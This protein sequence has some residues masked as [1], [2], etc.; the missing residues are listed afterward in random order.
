[1]ALN[2]VQ[3]DL[4]V[5][6]VST[7]NSLREVNLAMRQLSTN[8]A[9]VQQ[10]SAAFT[11][12]NGALTQGRER[13]ED[14]NAAIAAGKDGGLQGLSNL[15][16]NIAGSF[17][18]AT[19]ALG[20][21]GT[22]NEEINEIINKVNASVSLLSGIQAFADARRDAGIL[23]G[24]ALG[25]QQ[26]AQS[27]ANTTV[28]NI[29]TAST[30]ANTTATTANNVST[31][32]NTAATA[33]NTAGT[34]AGTTATGA[35]TTA[36]ASLTIAQRALNFVLSL[37]PWVAI[38]AAVAGAIA[39]YTKFTDNLNRVK[40]AYINYNN[41]T[42]KLAAEELIET[43]KNAQTKID[44]EQKIAD[45]R[46]GSRAK[47]IT[48]IQEAQKRE[49]DIFNETLKQQNVDL[50]LATDERARALNKFKEELTKSFS[51]SDAEVRDAI[52][53]T[54]SRDEEV[55]NAF[56]QNK[57][58]KE[59]LEENKN[60]NFQQKAEQAK[61][62]FSDKKDLIEAADILKEKSNLYDKE[63]SIAKLAGLKRTELLE[64]Q[65]TEIREF[66]DGQEKAAKEASKKLQEEFDKIAQANFESFA[67]EEELINRKAELRKKE[68][69]DLFDK[70]EKRK[71]TNKETIEDNKNLEFSLFLIEEEA[72][73]ARLA[74]KQKSIDE[75]AKLEAEK[76][77]RLIQLQEAFI[78]TT[79]RN[80]NIIAKNS[81]EAFDRRNAEITSA[82]DESLTILN[83]KLA[84]GKTTTE[85]YDL[86]LAE[87]NKKK[88]L[89]TSFND[90]EF[91]RDSLQEL[92]AYK[93]QEFNIF[94][95]A[96]GKQLNQIDKNK[97]DKLAKLQEASNEEFGVLFEALSN[98]TI[99]IDQYNQLKLKKQQEFENAKTNIV[100]QS[101]AE[102]IK[103]VA[104]EVNAE[105]QTYTT[106]GKNILDAIG[107]VSASRQA[108]QNNEYAVETQLRDQNYN[109]EI[110]SINAEYTAKVNAAKGD[111]D[112]LEAAAKEKEKQLA[113]AA[114]DKA[115]ADRDALAAQDKINEEAFE[116][117][118]KLQIAQAIIQTA[119]S[120]TGAFAS[121]AGIPIVGPVLGGIAAAAAVVAG[122][123]Q[124]N[125]IRKTKYVKATLP[126]LP[127]E[128]TDT[129]SAGTSAASSGST[130]SQFVGGFNFDNSSLFGQN[131]PF[132]MSDQRV[133]V[134]ESD[135]T[136]TQNRV[137]TIEDRNSF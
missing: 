12:M 5:N 37:N 10:G 100:K 92:E 118:K 32:T 107:A 6:T 79:D 136:S 104:D 121:L 41:E 28:T 7:S 116:N 19:G 55:I 56:V 42:R 14:L 54:K 68:L 127:N 73:N 23:R 49:T 17:G 16:R 78:V 96:L 40:A 134:L 83:D 34:V 8:L 80:D 88:N 75:T 4:L 43:S 45:A 74:L 65:R 51:V 133:Y 20:L 84:R 21:F 98:E 11:Q 120:A 33:A 66:N 119:Q 91:Y 30:A 132:P 60:L 77:A 25:Q 35:A 58:Y 67:S 24:L 95:T 130:A 85:K 57:K 81:K 108:I 64:K 129:T 47:T 115:V 62:I 18:V 26:L 38:I 126:S 76:N 123:A 9:G 87:L 94:Q 112:L 72:D 131:Y 70:S 90:L 110:D 117:S 46:R 135:I 97:E 13:I 3:I 71:K 27:A 29:N 109:N 52:F 44:L 1:M 86:D 125:T 122:S 36:T 93:Q 128:Y 31:A 82:Y 89:A 63:N 2:Q 124:I 111:K 106:L 137:K 113:K 50:A 48:E 59:F 101:S 102:R 15:G 61:K 22:K 69:Q 105:V 114:R 103:A 99:T 39:I 53:Q